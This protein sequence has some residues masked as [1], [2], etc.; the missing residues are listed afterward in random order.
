MSF[1]LDELIQNV[2]NEELIGQN[3]NCITD[4]LESET[5]LEE[6]L[7][8]PNVSPDND[9]ATNIMRIVNTDGV[10]AN[11]FSFRT[12]GCKVVYPGRIQM[13]NHNGTVKVVGAGIW[14]KP[15]PNASWD[16]SFSLKDNTIVHHTLKI[17]RV[18]KEKYAFV[19]ENSIPK[20]L[21][22]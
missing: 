13:I 9:L 15:N 18:I 5:T 21:V 7:V 14:I 1:N 8:Q 3:L 6:L 19:K 12:L 11:R 17:I 16:P 22:S 4:R 10:P 20:V 2:H